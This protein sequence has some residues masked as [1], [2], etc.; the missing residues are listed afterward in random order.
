VGVKEV[1]K[2]GAEETGKVV[3]GRRMRLLLE[4]MLNMCGGDWHWDR[5]WYCGSS[6]IQRK[7][8]RDKIFGLRSWS[9]GVLGNARNSLP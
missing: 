2:A 4:C 3:H 1:G 9:E 5:C 8:K 7:V 6:K